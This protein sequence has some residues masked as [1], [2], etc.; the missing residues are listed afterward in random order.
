MPRF[1][2]HAALPPIALRTLRAWR[3][4]ALATR[5]GRAAAALYYRLTR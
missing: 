3:D 4:R 5:L 1:L 2:E